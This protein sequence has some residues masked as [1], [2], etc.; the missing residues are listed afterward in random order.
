MEIIKTADHLIDLGPG[1][2]EDGGHIVAEGNPEFVATSPKSY[3]G[4]YLRKI[5]QQ[6]LI[7]KGEWS[8]AQQLV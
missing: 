5:I 6:D 7:E 2:G 3:T 4:R 1:G 8:K